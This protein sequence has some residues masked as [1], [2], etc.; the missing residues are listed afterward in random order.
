MSNPLHSR[1]ID[2][3]FPR[4]LPLAVPAHPDRL[5]Q[6]QYRHD[7]P[8]HASELV[9]TV[10][11]R[12]AIFR[13]WST[14]IAE[15]SAGGTGND[16]LIRHRPAQAAGDRC[17]PRPGPI[18]MPRA[19]RSFGR[20]HGQSGPARTA[21]LRGG[22]TLATWIAPGAANAIFL[23]SWRAI[24]SLDRKA[25]RVLLVCRLSEFVHKAACSLSRTS[26]MRGH[27]PFRYERH[28]R[29]TTAS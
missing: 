17:R 19:P 13:I 24:R 4:N 11:L 23:R 28:L 27:P 1:R 8:G 14:E 22:Q 18:R 15:G 12:G 9:P 21:D 25:A 2:P 29:T 5:R 3:A 7:P 20:I 26:A 16:R 10:T 6:S